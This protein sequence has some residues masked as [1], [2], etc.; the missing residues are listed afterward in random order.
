LVGPGVT[1]RSAFAAPLEKYVARCRFIAK[2]G[3]GWNR[4]AWMHNVF[5]LPVLTYV[6]QLQADDGITE[7]DLD[8]SSAILFK[9]PMHRPNFQFM[10]NLADLGVSYGLRSVRL[11]CQAAAA[12]SACTLPQLAAARRL[13]VIGSDD[14]HLAVHPLRAWQ[15]RC[16]ITRLGC[17][18]VRLRAEL[19]QLP[20]PPMIQKQCRSHLLSRLPRY[21]FHIMVHSRLVT[22]LRRMD[23]RY[24]D[25]SKAL[26]T[27]IL[28][29]VILAASVLHSS[30]MQAFIRVSQN[31]IVF[32]AG[33]GGRSECPLCGAGNATRLSH[34]LR[35]G[36]A[37]VFLA[38]HC[39]GLGWDFSDPSRF[40]FLLGSLV[41]DADSAAKL[42]LVWDFLVAGVSAG[43][44]GQDAWQACAARATAMARRPGHTGRVAASLTLPHPDVP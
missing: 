10:A 18:L 23:E 3:L 16:G 19:P 41:E 12:R 1:D 9:T 39:P 37:W 5:A 21:N 33:V 6:A 42:C 40:R 26:A 22:V 11:E 31:G 44:F 43:R 28:E 27:N 38:E 32:S 7:K 2:L 25:D 24:V 15:N 13:L 30:S 14:D 35:C 29:T 4:A 36:A 20:V 17:L 8:K 34:L